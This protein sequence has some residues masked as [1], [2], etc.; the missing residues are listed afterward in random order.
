MPD[1]TDI[2]ILSIL[3]SHGRRHLAEIAKEVD[4]SP[5][6]V[7]ERVKKLESRRIIMGYHALLDAKKVGKDITAFIGVSIS[8]QRYIEGFS[9]HVVAHEDVLECHHVTGEESFIL[10]AKTA[11][12][13]S[14][15]RLL[16]EIHSME[17]VTRTVTK[18]VLSTSKEGHILVLE[19]DLG[20]MQIDGKESGDDKEKREL[21]GTLRKR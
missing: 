15:E 5:P 20:K 10:K 13:A 8:H 6:A 1:A 11:N 4:L 12:T 18:V 3:Q 16:A 21:T 14:L 9:P 17:G 2:K 7:M 19:E